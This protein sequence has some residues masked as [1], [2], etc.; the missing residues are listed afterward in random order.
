MLQT[1]FSLLPLRTY[2]EVFKYFQP[3]LKNCVSIFK[4]V[5]GKLFNLSSPTL[6]ATPESK[7]TN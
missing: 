4:P 7:G 2:V 3:I 5:D 6:Q 1:V